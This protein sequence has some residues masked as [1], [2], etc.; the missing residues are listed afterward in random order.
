MKPTLAMLAAITL[1][2]CGAG[3][4]SGS[5]ADLAQTRV[6]SSPASAGAKSGFDAPSEGANTSLASRP[7]TTEA[8]RAVIRSGSLAVRVGDLE[9]SERAAGEII[10]RLEGYVDS[11]ESSDLAGKKP[12]LTLTARIPE[13]S[14]EQALRAFEGLGTR[15]SKRIAAQDVTGDIADNAARLTTMRAHE[16][17][18]RNVLKRAGDANSIMEAQR[19]LAEARM[20]IEGLQA[21]LDSVKGQAALSTIELRLEQSAEASAVQDP[22]WGAE[23]WASASTSAMNSFRIVV[24]AALWM[25]AYAP[26]WIVGALVY[27]SLRARRKSRPT[28]EP[29]P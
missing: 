8:R 6:A 29:A 7:R 18:L 26:L 16:E 14:F 28:W 4:P 5:S 9:K 2:G 27:R 13:T 3:A 20:E 10:A 15:L 21:R 24:G 17:S 22:R 23:A 1:A 25:L 19:R 12:V 11:A